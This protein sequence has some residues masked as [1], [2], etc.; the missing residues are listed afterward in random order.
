MSRKD[1]LERAKDLVDNGDLDNAY[2]LADR[3]LREN[4]NDVM[5]M[6][7]MTAVM[8]NSHKPT[9]GYSLAKRCTQLAPKEPGVWL[10]LG[11]A[12]N[13]LWLET[14]A[15]R[16]YR[17]ALKLARTDEQR[18]MLCVNLASVM[19]DTGRFEEAEPYCEMAIEL[20][21]ATEKGVANLGFCQLA[22]RKWKEGWKNYRKCLGTEWRPLQQYNKEP[23]WEGQTEVFGRRPKV[24]LYAEQGLGD[25]ISFASM[26]PDAEKDVDIVLDVDERLKNLFQRSFPGIKVYG[27]RHKKQLIWKEEDTNPDFSLPMGQIGEYYRLQD[28]DFPGT[29]YLTADPDRVIQWKALFD[30]KGKP[31]IGIA[32]RGGIPKTGSKFRQWDLEQLLPILKSVDAHWVSLQYKP[33]SKEIEAF[34][35]DHPEIDL[36]EYQHRTLTNDYDDTVAMIAAM[37]HVVTMQTAVVHVAGGLG[38]PCWAHVPMN[39]QW[40]YGSK[41]EEFPWAESVR[42]IRQNTRGH[43]EDVIKTT[44][45]ELHAHFSRVRKA[46]KGTPQDKGLRGNGSEVR[47]NGKPNNRQGGNKSSSRLRV[48]KQSKPKGH[49]APEGEDN[50]SSV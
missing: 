11:M 38:V 2:V 14:E 3:W 36:V 33:A 16:H 31:A 25:I 44:A 20:N 32:W 1:D 48:R 27:T 12:A 34:K 42:I 43:W 23:L 30:S 18:S 28:D 17:K 22:Q 6:T 45:E 41:G 9:I 46:A 47:A 7:I 5:F 4:P 19:I 40:R 50:V 49:P 26:I 15:E 21:D 35:K 13:D 8:L 24:V 39:S 37:D 10:N 29:P